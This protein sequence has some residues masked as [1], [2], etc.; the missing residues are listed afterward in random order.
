MQQGPARAGGRGALA[1][2]E[3]RAAMLL[4]KMSALRPDFHV[5]LEGGKLTFQGLT[6]NEVPTPLFPQ[7]L[8]VWSYPFFKSF[9]V[10]GLDF[11]SSLS[12]CPIQF[13]FSGEALKKCIFRTFHIISFQ[14]LTEFQMCNLGIPKLVA[15]DYILFFIWWKCDVNHFNN[16]LH[17]I[18]LLPLLCK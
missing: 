17:H 10:W 11:I 2:L 18:H 14:W 9:L 13:C 5:S 4:L 1:A 3:C 15:F 7:F 6:A 8:P 12:A 16:S